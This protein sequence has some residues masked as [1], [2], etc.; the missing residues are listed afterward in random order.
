MTVV[1]ILYLGLGLALGA[2]YFW[3]VWRTVRL[4]LDGA[5]AGWIALHYAGRLALAALALWWVAQA[6]AWP[7]LACFAGFLLARL[8]A[9]RL[10][11][12]AR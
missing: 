2:G 10:M 5:P 7:L 9:T 1:L 8:A 11:R 4:H 12:E 3:I 6:G